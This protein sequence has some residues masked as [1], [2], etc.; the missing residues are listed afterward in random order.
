MSFGA[1]QYESKGSRRAA[2]RLE[3]EVTAL[4]YAGGR[5]IAFISRSP[6]SCFQPL[7]AILTSEYTRP[8]LYDRAH[9]KL[10]ARPLKARPHA[11][12]I[13]QLRIPA[14][15]RR[16]RSR[17]GRHGPRACP[18]ARGHRHHLRNARLKLGVAR[19]RSPGASRPGIFPLEIGRRKYA[20][21]GGLSSDRPDSRTKAWA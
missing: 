18:P 1:C 2:S 6:A 5:S 21:D 4:G 17:H 15:G 16:R 11:N 8:F 3:R 19:R 20:L 10:F 13:L 7:M 9:Y 12:P 14:A